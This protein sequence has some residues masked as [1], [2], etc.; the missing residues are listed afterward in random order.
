[1]KTTAIAAAKAA[2]PNAADARATAPP[3]N[4]TAKRGLETTTTTTTRD[5][6]KNWAPPAAAPPPPP[7]PTATAK[8][9]KHD[10]G[11]SARNRVV[12]EDPENDSPSDGEDQVRYPNP[13]AWNKPGE[14]RGGDDTA[15]AG[16]GR[17][18]RG[19]RGGGRGKGAAA[20]MKSPTAAE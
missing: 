15:G 17:G 3:P 4:A 12:R 10:W 20:R 16:G 9:P 2:A 6:E 14:R 18:G 13:L 8:A 1:M 7:P 11:A 5:W 19:G